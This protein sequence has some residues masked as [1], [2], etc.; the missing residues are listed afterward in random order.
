M[1]EIARIA[2]EKE[3]AEI[4]NELSK[5]IEENDKMGLIKNDYWLIIKDAKKKY[6]NLEKQLHYKVNWRKQ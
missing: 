5:S 3:H 6:K 2:Q 1:C 4:S